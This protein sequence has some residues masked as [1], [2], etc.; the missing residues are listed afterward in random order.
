MKEDNRWIN[1]EPTKNSY[2]WSEETDKAEN[3][4]EL[5]VKD[6]S[7]EDG[8]LHVEIHLHASGQPFRIVLKPNNKIDSSLFIRDL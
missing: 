8:R 1:G 4:I 7:I 5:H 2:Q 6:V 3:R